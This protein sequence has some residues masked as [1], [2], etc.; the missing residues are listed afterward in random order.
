MKFFT[1]DPHLGHEGI[2]ESCRRPFKNAK[3]M[4]NAIIKNINFSCNEDDE[5]YILGDLSM[6]TAQH[7]GRLEQWIKKIKPRIHLITGNHDIRNPILLNELGIQ[8]IHYPY[9]EVEEFI[10]VHDPS[11][12]CIDRSR[13]FLCGHVHDLFVQVQNAFNVGVDVHNFL[14]LSITQ[15]REMFD[16]NLLRNGL[17]RE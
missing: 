4:A 1:A 11:L 10:C 16:E 13:K 3:I 9:L 12:S 7:A 14:P 2:I 6:V 5:L 17:T 8:S 15:V